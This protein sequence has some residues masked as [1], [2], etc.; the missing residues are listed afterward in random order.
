L[1]NRLG[2]LLGQAHRAHRRIAE[3]GLA[4]LGL[5]AKEFGGLSVLVDE[6]PLS[7]QRLGERMR[8]DRTTMVAVVDGLER[9]GFAERERDPRDR[10]AYAVRAT[11]KGRRVLRDAYKAAERAEAEFLAPLGEADR[12]R[13]KE[14]LNRL[15]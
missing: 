13:F 15:I 2:Y 14:L 9:K 6:G 1:A 10:R 11:P 8:V 5:G 12:R 3:E 7:Q 4:R